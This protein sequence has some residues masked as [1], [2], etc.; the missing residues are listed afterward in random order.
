MSAKSTPTECNSCHS[1]D[2]I[3]LGRNGSECQ[4]CHNETRWSKV[5]FHHDQDTDF[6]LTGKHSNLG[7]NQCHSGTLQDPLSRDCAGCHR[8][9]DIH[10]DSSMAL[11][12]TCHNTSSW[13]AV[14]RFDHDLSLF[15]LLGMHRTVP[16]QSCHIGN[17]FSLGGSDCHSCHQQDDKHQQALGSDCAQCHT[18]NAWALWQFDHSKQTD[19][20]LNGK[21]LGLECTACHQPGTDPKDT[22]RLCGGCH[23]QQDI[24]NGEFGN[25]CDR[26]HGTSNFFDL[27]LDSP[28]FSGGE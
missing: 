22:P 18:P 21:H 16:C 11:C 4:Q 10:N 23:R 17:Q 14:G 24:H 27:N 7:C 26:C 2:D 6:P 12:G 25:R 19:F 1:G 8:A 3:H 5:L 13:Q 20:H 28:S 9:D 15:P